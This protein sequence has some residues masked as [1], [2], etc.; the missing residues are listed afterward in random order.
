[1]PVSTLVGGIDMLAMDDLAR[2]V[3]AQEIPIGLLT[4]LVGTPIFL[5]LLWRSGGRGWNAQ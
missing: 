4:A 2:T 1:M 5:W 3:S